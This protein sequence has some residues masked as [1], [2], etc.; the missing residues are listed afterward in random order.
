MRHRAIQEEHSPAV[1]LKQVFRC[2][3]R[4][5]GDIDVNDPLKER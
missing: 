4:E 5:P 1:A 2:P 3:T